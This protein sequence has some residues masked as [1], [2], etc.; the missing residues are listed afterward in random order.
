M[1][2]V[3]VQSKPGDPKCDPA[4]L[5][6]ASL[7]GDHRV[8]EGIDRYVFHFG[9]AVRKFCLYALE[10]MSIRKFQNVVFALC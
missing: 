1:A 5:I 4:S 10:P 7:T 8:V 9:L 2:S 3:D 6:H